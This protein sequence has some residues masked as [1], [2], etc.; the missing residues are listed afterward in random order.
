MHE[1]MRVRWFGAT[2]HA[3]ICDPSYHIATPISR[4]CLFCDERIAAEDQ[5]VVM[6]SETPLGT[7]AHL[8]CL[9]RAVSGAHDTAPHNPHIRW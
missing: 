9:L 3:P 1:E 5:G 6:A 7:V 4:V 2:W 8:R